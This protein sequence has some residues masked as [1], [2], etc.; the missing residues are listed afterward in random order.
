MTI[1]G[2]YIIDSSMEVRNYNKIIFMSVVKE[3]S[4]N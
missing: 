1:I 2:N 3:E 4:K